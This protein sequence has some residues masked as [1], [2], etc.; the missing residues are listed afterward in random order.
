MRVYIAGP[1][2]GLP[3]RNYAAFEH[4]ASRLRAQGHEVV[5]PAEINDGLEHEGYAACMKRD[6]LALVEC[7]AIQ[8]LPGW[9]KSR[10]ACVEHGIARA[11]DML[12]F[13]PGEEV[14]A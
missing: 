12:V 9:E 5:S 2:T 3:G 14:V 4:A 6:I 1:M 10:G 11:L 13:Q 7:R 8:M